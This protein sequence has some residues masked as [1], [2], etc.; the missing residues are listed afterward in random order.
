MF[1]TRRRVLLWTLLAGVAFSPE[2]VGALPFFR[3]VVL[4]P[5]ALLVFA[6]Y[7][8]SFA[9]SKYPARAALVLL[10]VCFAVTLCDLAAR[11]LLFYLSGARPTELFL[12]RWPPL[13]LLLR[14]TPGINFEGVTFGGLAASARRK[15]WR[16][17]RRV[18]FVSDAYGFRNE[19]PDAGT[20]GRPL[21]VIVL[22]DSFG[23]AASTSQELTLS[24]VLARDHG[25]GVYNLTRTSGACGRRSP[26]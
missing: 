11:P 9:R 8:F 20:S 10:S 24:S 21:D 22:G 19:P 7:A 16:E 23:A 15:D 14:Y 26:P 6:V 17:E 12:R 13:P 4:L 3:G 5:A 2:A 25:F 18:R 1:L